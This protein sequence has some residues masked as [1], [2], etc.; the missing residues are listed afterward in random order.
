MQCYCSLAK[1]LATPCKKL[2]VMKAEPKQAEANVKR[3]LQASA[4][5]TQKTLD[6]D[7]SKFHYLPFSD[8]TLKL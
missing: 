8:P 5:K 2:P 4:Q 3:C 1:G 6:G 7:P